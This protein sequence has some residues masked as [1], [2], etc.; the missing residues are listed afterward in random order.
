LHPP[1][2]AYGFS[3]DFATTKPL[4]LLE[5]QFHSSFKGF[6]KL[7]F[8]LAALVLQSGIK[9][10]NIIGR[11]KCH[12]HL[13]FGIWHLAFGIWHLTF[14]IWHLAFGIWHLAFGI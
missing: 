6:Q 1:F 13:P 11:T 8:M 10:I 9:I 12:R 7:F 5:P 14:G 4:E 2:L 3:D